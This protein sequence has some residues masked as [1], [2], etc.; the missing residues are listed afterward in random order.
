[1]KLYIII[2]IIF[3]MIYLN[4]GE[5]N[6][7]N[8]SKA[9]YKSSC[10]NYPTLLKKVMDEREMTQSSNY[11]YY[12]P[13]S[14]NSCEKDVLA[15]EN[16]SGKKLFFIDGCDV[17]ASKLELWTTIK[18]YFGK[19]A[20]KY[21]PLTYLL[22]DKQDLKDFPKHFEENKKKNPNQMYILKNYE[23]RQEG[24]KLTKDLNTIMDGIKSG[25][26][27][28]QDYLYNPYIINKR[29]INLRYYLLIV[30]KNGTI[31]GYIHRNGF[32][33]YTPK[34]YDPNNMDFERHIT[35]GY[36]DR[37]V[38]A[39]NPLTLK[40]FR[41]HLDKQGLR[42]SEKHDRNINQ[43]FNN[44]MKALSKSICKNKKLD[45][46]IRFQLFGCDIAP[47][48]NLE[49]KL[50]EINKGPDLDAKDERDKQVKIKVQ[51]DLFKKIEEDTTDINNEFT[52]IY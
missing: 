5:S 16:K 12:M 7:E 4:R 33:Y 30:C 35:T 2:A 17:L 32:I 44:I 49:P 42:L 23:Q 8:F 25:W 10:G 6:V 14:Y 22:E 1:M 47:D 52:K 43:L 18:N 41:E 28:V 26:Y 38:Y 3:I 39:E 34:Y 36:I 45:K 24:L 37:Q 19:D 9:T 11:D 50:I 20:Y 40:D 21:V 29:K 31:T 15:F 13:C 51:Q 46:N 48:S 27:L